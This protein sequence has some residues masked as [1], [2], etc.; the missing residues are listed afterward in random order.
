MN[1]ILSNFATII[2]SL[3]LIAAVTGIIVHLRHDRKKGKSLCGAKCGCCP[4]SSLC[5]K[6]P[7]VNNKEK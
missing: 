6:A 5:H 7:A 3:I 4:M 1:W 2:I